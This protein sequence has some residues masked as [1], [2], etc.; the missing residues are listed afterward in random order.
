MKHFSIDKGNKFQNVFA[1]HS[2]ELGEDYIIGDSVEGHFKILR[3]HHNEHELLYELEHENEAVFPIAQNEEFAFFATEKETSS[4]IMSN[5]IYLQKGDSLVYE[6]TPEMEK[7]ILDGAICK[8]WLEFTV[9]KNDSTFEMQSECYKL[10][11]I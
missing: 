4:G 3:V 10:I 9:Y 6:D 11:E 2:A 7:A 5:I 8:Q 1:Y